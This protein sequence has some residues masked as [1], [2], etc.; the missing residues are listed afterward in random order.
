MKKK[1]GVGSAHWKR[2][3]RQGW[4]LS[5]LIPVKGGGPGA[6]APSGQ[7]C[8]VKGGCLGGRS[9][10]WKGKGGSNGACFIGDAAGSGGQAAGGGEV[11]EGGRGV[12]PA[13]RSGA[14][15]VVG[16][17]PTA[18]RDRRRNRGRWGLTG[19]TLLQFWAMAV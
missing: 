7:G 11:W 19:G 1:R 12:G 13:R 9:W 10:E 16:S 14:R 4:R 5:G 17:G 6:R 2:V 8:G 3:A 18:A 15:G